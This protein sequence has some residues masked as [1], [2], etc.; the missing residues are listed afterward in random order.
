MINM[1]TPQTFANTCVGPNNLPSDEKLFK[2]GH[3]DTHH[4]TSNTI[5][6]IRLTG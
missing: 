3:T 4:W 1:S 6:W 5:P 2:T